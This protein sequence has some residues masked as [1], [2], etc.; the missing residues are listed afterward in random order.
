MGEVW[1]ARDLRLA[2]TVALKVLPTELTRNDD[3]VARFQ[4]EARATSALNHPNVCTIHA[5]GETTEG[6][7]FIVMEHIAGDSLRHISPV[8]AAAS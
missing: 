2:R 1:L 5:L 7:Q 8:R 4:Q 6:Q 3:R